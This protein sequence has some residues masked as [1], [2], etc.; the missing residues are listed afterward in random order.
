MAIG[1]PRPSHYVAREVKT[2]RFKIARGWPHARVSWQ[3]TGIRHDAD[4][5][6]HRIQVEGEKQGEDRGRYLQPELFGHPEGEAIG[7]TPNDT[8]VGI[9]SAAAGQH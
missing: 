9:T 3:L 2:S 4:A 6:A 1:A 8:A 5:N 7:T